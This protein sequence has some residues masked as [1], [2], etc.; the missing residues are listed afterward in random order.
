MGRSDRGLSV[1]WEGV[2][3]LSVSWEG[4]TGGSVFHGRE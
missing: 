2:T 3:G 4:V 1:S